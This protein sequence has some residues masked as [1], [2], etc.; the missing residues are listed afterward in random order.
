MSHQV[1]VSSMGEQELYA[2]IESNQ[3]VIGGAEEIIERAQVRRRD[4]RKQKSDLYRS[5]LT[6]AELG[7]TCSE[8]IIEEPVIRSILS[9]HEGSYETN[10]TYKTHFVLEYKRGEL[11]FEVTANRSTDDPTPQFSIVVKYSDKTG[12]T[13]IAK[14]V[15]AWPFF[16]VSLEGGDVFIGEGQSMAAEAF[17]DEDESYPDLSIFG[18]YAEDVG[19]CMRHIEAKTQEE[20]FYLDQ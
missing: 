19:F 2:L 5:S 20:N 7:I 18:K 15:N 12:G 8:Y 3:R 14:Y 1:D 4:L 16:R 11:S 9:D 17:H 6:D 13:I 10:G